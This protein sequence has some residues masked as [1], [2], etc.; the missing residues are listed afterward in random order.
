MSILTS[1]RLARADL[2]LRKTPSLSPSAARD[3]ALVVR[4]S[5]GDVVVPL[6]RTVESLGEQ[7]ELVLVPRSQVGPGGVRRLGGGAG[8]GMDPSRALRHSFF[9][10]LGGFVKCLAD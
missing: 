8:A 7:H 3:W 4:L 2:V 5:D 9:V 10:T 1:P 6:D